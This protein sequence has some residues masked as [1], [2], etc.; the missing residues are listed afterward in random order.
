MLSKGR[1]SSFLEKSQDVNCPNYMT[2]IECGSNVSD[3]IVSLVILAYHLENS[4]LKYNGNAT[5][6]SKITISVIIMQ[7]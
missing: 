2:S 7:H 1:E 4:V 6:S 5:N 3:I